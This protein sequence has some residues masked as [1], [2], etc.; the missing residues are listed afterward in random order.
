[1]KLF[2]TP[3]EGGDQSDAPLIK[4][5]RLFLKLRM[6]PELDEPG[7]MSK[8]GRISAGVG[9]RDASKA[10][11]NAQAASLGKTSNQGCGKPAGLWQRC[12]GDGD[13]LKS[14]DIARPGDVLRFERIE[15][16]G[17]ETTKI[18]RL[19]TIQRAESIM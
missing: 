10:A 19:D 13:V 2:C 3:L 16:P 4:P 5:H 7:G 6:Y 11:H 15:M 8:A 14:E 12:L 9:R 18:S 17:C 1:M